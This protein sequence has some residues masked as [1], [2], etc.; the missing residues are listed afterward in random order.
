MLG[1]LGELRTV[2][3]LRDGSGVALISKGLKV[4]PARRPEL[5]LAD[6]TI[7]RELCL[8][9]GDQPF[10]EARVKLVVLFDRVMIC[11]A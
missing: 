8:G 3:E 7:E 4:H 9:V 6:R 1:V 2:V 10:D 5:A 11:A